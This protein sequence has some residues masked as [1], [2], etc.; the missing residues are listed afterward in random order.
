MTKREKILE[1]AIK[2][3]SEEGYEAVGVQKIAERAGV[4]KPTLYHYFNSKEGLLA[5]ILEE[6]FS[7]FLSEL[8]VYSQSKE[9]IKL[10]LENIINH[11]FGFVI[12]N[13]EFYRLL[14]ALMFSPVKSQS[15]L[16]VRE[17][18]KKQ[19]NLIEKV[20][21]EGEK[22]YG[23]M[24]GRSMIFTHNFIGIINAAITYYYFNNNKDDLSRWRAE[25]LCRQFMYG[26]FN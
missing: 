10:L 14:L 22:H 1:V 12:N 26:I 5:V 2:L 16:A 8:A 18:L 17:Q 15:Y 13:G 21:K 11:Y 9:H 7:E 19:Y 23:N 3:F 4:T 24:K 20:F 6:G 25:E